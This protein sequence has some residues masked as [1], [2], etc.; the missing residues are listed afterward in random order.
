MDVNVGERLRHLAKMPN[1]PEFSS[2]KELIRGGLGFNG[3]RSTRSTFQASCHGVGS[4]PRAALVPRLP[5][6]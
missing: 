1:R 6:G 3:G 5:L 2:L 4:G